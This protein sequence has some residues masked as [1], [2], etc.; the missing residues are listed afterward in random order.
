MDTLFR[1]M[2]DCARPSLPFL[3]ALEM[4]DKRM[5]I[6]GGDVVLP[7]RVLEG[8]DVMVEGGRF[9]GI[10]RG[11]AQGSGVERIDA[12]GARVLPGLIDLHVHGARGLVV[13]FD[14]GA[15]DALSEALAAH[16]VT[17]FLPTLAPMPIRDFVEAVSSVASGFESCKGAQPL[18]LNL[19]GPFINPMNSGALP[20]ECMIPPSRDSLRAMLDAACGKARIM[21]VAPEL[22]GALEIVEL[23]NEEGVI[24]SAGHTDA[25]FEAVEKAVSRGL[26]HVTHCFNAMRRFSHREPGPMEAALLLD[27]LSVEIICDGRHVKKPAIDILFR[28]KPK[29]RICAV[30]DATALDAPSGRIRLGNRVL[31]VSKGIVRDVE[32]GSLGGSSVAILTGV[33]NLANLIGLPMHAAVAC[34]SLNPA[35][36]LGI[37]ETAGSIEIGKKADFCLVTKGWEILATYSAG[38]KIFQGNP[39][40]G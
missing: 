23:L 15:L 22:P 8:A 1:P 6:A 13:G 9:A 38:K 39:E 35:S 27:R 19:E 21:T 17:G 40:I 16:G 37:A 18:G 32:T 2:Y 5:L 24:P 7:D 12:G 28:C 26:A 25:A 20:Q 31:E 4:E 34:A 14:P 36:V 29:G 30:S 11:L 33:R 3:K 10:G